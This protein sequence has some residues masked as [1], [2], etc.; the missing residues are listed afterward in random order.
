M[1]SNVKEPLGISSSISIV[2]DKKIGNTIL[3][4]TEFSD[5]KASVTD[6]KFIAEIKQLLDQLAKTAV[7]VAIIIILSVALAAALL[8]MLVVDIYVSEYKSFMIM[9]KSMGYT[10]AQ[11]I[12]FTVRLSVF[13][14]LIVIILTVIMVFGI[15][16]IINSILYVRGF[17]LPIGYS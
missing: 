13:A 1:Y 8:I 14:S 9:L 4:I 16:S 6:L 12:D 10:N 17:V 2:A 15:V 11:I 3:D 7:Y 5:Y